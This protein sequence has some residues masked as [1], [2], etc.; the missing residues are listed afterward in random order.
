M[1]RQQKKAAEVLSG[2]L[3][4]KREIERIDTVLEEYNKT[5]MPAQKIKEK[6]KPCHVQG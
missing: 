2:Y 1:N 4:A 3:R 5:G 6:Q